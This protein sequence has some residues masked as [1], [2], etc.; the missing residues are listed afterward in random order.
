MV[1]VHRLSL[2]L[3][4]LTLAALLSACGGKTVLITGTEPGAEPGSETDSGTGGG[5]IG[6]DSGTRDASRTGPNG[7]VDVELPAGGQDCN[8]ASDCTVIPTGYI[9]PSQCLCRGTGTAVNN[10]TYESIMA[11][12]ASEAWDTCHCAVDSALVCVDH[13]CTLCGSGPDEPLECGDGGVIGYDSGIDYDGSIDYEGG[14]EYDGSIEYDGGVIIEDGGVSPPGQCPDESTI[15]N[16]KPCATD[17]LECT[18]PYSCP[19]PDL[20]D[21]LVCFLQGDCVGHLVC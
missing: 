8:T 7:C 6:V 18:G 19:P 1:I 4:P 14:I 3:A 21:P 5:T 16:G 10:T 13:I 12:P 20:R 2:T 9:C 15:A 11:G 17:G